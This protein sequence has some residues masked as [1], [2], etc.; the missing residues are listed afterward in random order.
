MSRIIS[1]HKVSE[2]I[3]NISKDIKPEEV[4]ADKRVK[5]ENKEEA[6]KFV[7]DLNLEKYKDSID[8]DNISLFILHRINK[9][10]YIRRN[11]VEEAEESFNKI[12]GWSMSAEY[13]DCIEKQHEA[14]QIMKPYYEARQ[15]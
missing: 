8:F 14:I 11:P 6:E 3:S 4:M 15:K 10:G 13:R 9:A 12:K 7:N 2:I 1:A 5:F